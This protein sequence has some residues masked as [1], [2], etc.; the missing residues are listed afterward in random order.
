MKQGKM[1]FYNRPSQSN[2]T[3]LPKHSTVYNPQ[4]FYFKNLTPGT[5]LQY[6]FKED[7]D[8]AAEHNI[9]VRNRRASIQ[10]NKVDANQWFVSILAAPGLSARPKIK[11]MRANAVTSNHLTGLCAKCYGKNSLSHVKRHTYN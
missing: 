5:Q 8:S 6:H 11:S 1:I 3:L 4:A 10:L 7:T 2:P 9:P